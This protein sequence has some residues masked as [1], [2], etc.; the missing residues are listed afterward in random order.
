MLERED[1]ETEEE[2]KSDTELATVST[3]TWTDRSGGWTS[4]TI[5]TVVSK[6]SDSTPKATL[7]DEVSVESDW[8]KSEDEVESECP[9][10]E[11]SVSRHD[12]TTS[13]IV[14]HRGSSDTTFSTTGEPANKKEE[15]SDNQSETETPPAD[16]AE[17]EH[18]RKVIST[19]VTI[20]CLTVTIKEAP[21]A[22]GFFKGY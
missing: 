16:P 5:E 17:D 15:G 2:E 14:S 11:S 10:L 22:K 9:K 1:F 12:N 7:D 21:V 8:F 18:P 20:N 4:E 19:D 3:D 13:V 6:D